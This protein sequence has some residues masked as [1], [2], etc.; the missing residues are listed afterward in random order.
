MYCPLV[1]SRGNNPL[2]YIAESDVKTLLVQNIIRGDASKANLLKKTIANATN[3]FRRYKFVISDMMKLSEVKRLK[4]IECYLSN[5]DFFYIQ[6]KRKLDSRRIDY[7]SLQKLIL[8]LPTLPLNLK[9]NSES[10]IAKQY[11]NKDPPDRKE[12]KRIYNIW[13]KNFVNVRLR[14]Q[15]VIFISR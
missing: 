6:A 1:I 2:F 11:F 15:Q 14:V 13:S 3:R 4:R 12:V 5:F 8:Q 7:A 9:A 10:F